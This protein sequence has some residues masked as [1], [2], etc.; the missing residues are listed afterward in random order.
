[1]A[2]QRL[3]RRKSPEELRRA[4][5][6][7]PLILTGAATEEQ[8]RKIQRVL[9]SRGAI[10][11]IF[12]SAEKPAKPP[13]PQAP[14]PPSPERETR[15]ASERLKPAI[16]AK[17]TP[18]TTERP[19][20][21]QDRR[22][23]PRVH[24]GIQLHPMG[25]GQI[26]DRTFRL[27]RERFWLFLVIMLIPLA[28]AAGLGVILGLVSA[29]MGL[30]G[31]STGPP[32]GATF[33]IGMFFFFLV[34]LV[35]LFVLQ[36]WAQGALI[37]AVSETYL[38]HQTTV[39]ASYKA[40]LPRLA[41][42]I[43]TL[44]L[45][46]VLIALAVGVF[47][48]L[49]AVIILPLLGQLLGSLGLIGLIVMSSVGALFF[50]V[51]GLLLFLNWLLADKVVVLEGLGGWAALKRSRE[52]M[53]ALTES[54]FW[55]KPKVKAGLILLVAF[56]IGMAILLLF[57]IPQLILQFLIPENLLALTLIQALYIVGNSLA[58]AFAGM[59]IILYYYDIRIR[60]EGFD[61]KMMAEKL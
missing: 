51:P 20:I 6:R 31:A 5:G 36:V 22:A 21:Q 56:L 9:E 12:Y 33:G 46:A 35:L 43:L 19:P 7:L 3:Y 16:A 25:V 37:S 52:L 30:M 29:G 61:L 8:A 13:E 32:M 59:A 58:T 26:L 54:G 45:M 1:L 10:L 50:I 41:K 4:L 38:G 11:E 28:V 39:S 55:K 40:M 17:P 44:L 2:L 24:P 57:Q 14:K 23:K 15:P 60:K 47:G 34:S 49:G 18:A 27:L 42:L 53:T 48:A